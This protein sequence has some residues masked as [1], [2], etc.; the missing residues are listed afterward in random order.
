MGTAI[1]VYKLLLN[2]FSLIKKSNQLLRISH[3]IKLLRKSS[4]N[5]N[6]GDLLFDCN[7]KFAY[8]FIVLWFM[9]TAIPSYKLLLDA[10]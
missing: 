5:N 1:P 2:I 10:L 8:V 7:R 3:D 6:S 9:G 4:N